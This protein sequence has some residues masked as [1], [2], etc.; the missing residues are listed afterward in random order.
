MRVVISGHGHE[1]HYFRAHRGVF[2][3]F[4]V[5]AKKQ[6]FADFFEHPLYSQCECSRMR[7]MKCVLQ[8]V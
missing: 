2:H 8:I 5:R 6:M 1:T 4:V 3:P 7:L